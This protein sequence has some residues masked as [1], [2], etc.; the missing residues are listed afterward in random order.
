MNNN[1]L[2]TI[3]LLEFRQLSQHLLFFKQSTSQSRKNICM[4]VIAVTPKPP[5]YAAILLSVRTDNSEGYDEMTARM[6]ELAAQQPGYIGMEFARGELGIAI[7]YW[8][9]LEA[10]TAWKANIEHLEAQRR[11]RE[12]WYSKGQVRICRVEADYGWG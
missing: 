9:S 1:N 8:E 3:C 4:S 7:C 2:P 10:I 12:E 5:Y 6:D 11:G